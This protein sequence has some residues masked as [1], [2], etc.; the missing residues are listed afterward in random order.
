MT[1]IFVQ[2]L[3]CETLLAGHCAQCEGNGIKSRGSIGRK[4]KIALKVNC[5]GFSE[6]GDVEGFVRL[7]SFEELVVADLKPDCP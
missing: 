7:Y 1:K 3:S 2:K 6:R 4:T 5:H